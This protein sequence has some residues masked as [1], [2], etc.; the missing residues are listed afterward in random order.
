M[1]DL[2]A[3][4]KRALAICDQCGFQTKLKD[5]KELVR[6]RQKTNLRVCPECWE[7]DHPQY[8]V[9]RYPVREAI[10]VRNPRPDSTYTQ[11]GLTVRGTVSMGSRDIQWG[12]NPV[13]L[14]NPLGLSGLPNM[15]QADAVLGHVSVV[16]E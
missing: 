1:P 5:L 9:G 13:G 16:V 12:W 6:N 8:D 3:S 10:S 11:G 15:L 7:A 4:G 2:Y 14:R